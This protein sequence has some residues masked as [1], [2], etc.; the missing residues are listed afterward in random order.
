MHIHRSNDK[1]MDL[2]QLKHLA[3]SHLGMEADHSCLIVNPSFDPAHGVLVAIM[4]LAVII[5]SHSVNLQKPSKKA[6]SL[7]T[8]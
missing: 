3:N 8:I 7:S 2:E 5:S 6:L 1:E 4:G